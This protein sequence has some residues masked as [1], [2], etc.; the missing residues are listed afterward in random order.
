MPFGVPNIASAGVAVIPDFGSF[1]GQLESGLRSNLSGPG[2]AAA[3][4]VAGLGVAVAGFADQ[5]VDAFLPF[6]ASLSKIV[7]LTGTAQAQVDQWGRDVLALGPQ[8][9]KS[10]QEMG[11]ALLFIASSGLQ[12]AAAMDAL[13]KSAKASA[14]GLGATETVADA[15]TSAINAYG[16]A[17][18]SAGEATD[19]LVATVREGKAEAD[20]LAGS[21][22]AVIPIAAQMGVSFDQVGGAIAAMTLRG[23][24]A[25]EATTA[26][27]GIL[28]A[29]LNPSQQAV[30]RLQEVGLSFGE[31]RK[32][33][34][35]E[36][37]LDTLLVLEEAFRGNEEAMADVF[38]D[39]RGLTGV[40]NLVGAGAEQTRDVM[41]ELA[42]SA[43]SLNDA[44]AAVADDEGFKLKQALEEINS[45]MIEAGERI[46]PNL[47]LALKA[48][49]PIITNDVIPAVTDLALTFADFA[50]SP[51]PG[52]LVDFGTTVGRGLTAASHGI[53]LV[54][55]A[56]NP[57]NREGREAAK[58]A[59]LM[60]IAINEV[61]EAVSRGEGQLEAVADQLS[62]VARNGEATA[63]E[64]TRLAAAGRL[65][66]DEMA[67]V[68]K[69][70]VN[71]TLAGQN[72]S[73]SL[74]ELQLVFGAFLPNI[75]QMV[76]ATDSWVNALARGKGAADE[77]GGAVDP[78]AALLS[79]LGIQTGEAADEAG[80]LA[81]RL[82][83]ATIAQENLGSLLLAQANPVLNMVRQVSALSE[84][85]SQIDKDGKRTTEEQ[86]AFGEQRLETFAAIAAANLAGPQEA[87]AVL[88]GAIGVIPDEVEAMLTE[89]GILFDENADRF[90]VDLVEGIAA[91]VRR[92]AQLLGIA[93]EE[94]LFNAQ[95]G[96]QPLVI[97]YDLQFDKM[98]FPTPEDFANAGLSGGGIGPN[99][100]Q[101]AQG[102]LVSN[103]GPVLR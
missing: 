77:T 95:Q 64:F 44:F 41:D 17:V 48:I 26:L 55:A 40:L 1:R 10:A 62:F 61:L 54:V 28:V 80:R 100:W 63:E 69:A 78:L 87:I 74:G 13:E 29:L 11:D 84:L 38:D 93:L 58:T 7:G 103:L 23:L 83:A 67:L 45:E 50:K 102:Q 97:P 31:L 94:V 60:D 59:V 96:L 46:V 82:V 16:P 20:Q 79:E 71:A 98:T 9:G 73:F 32:R 2:L 47:V 22:G 21:I 24:D 35:D 72:T 88:A 76:G 8:F 12:G 42:N 101:L 33:I 57:F 3:A 34:R 99:A 4:G 68:A 51:V 81:D 27:R 86:F 56:L 53:G 19:V 92:N 91:S 66:N 90:G 6:E 15:V 25:S 65:T 5:A 14:A 75:A 30:E 39:V 70:F 43:G 36:G 37:L 49:T 52:A 85:I 89:T 18:L